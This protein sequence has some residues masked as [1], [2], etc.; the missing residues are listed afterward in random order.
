MTVQNTQYLMIVVGMK[1]IIAQ[2]I[3]DMEMMADQ[4]EWKAGE[5]LA[6]QKRPGG[7]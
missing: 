3:Y 6:N 1:E 2:C 7:V 5:G 4:A